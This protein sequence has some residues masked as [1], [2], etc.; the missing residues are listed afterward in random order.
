MEMP[1][2]SQRTISLL[3]LRWPASAIASWRDAFH[4]VAVG[5]EHIGVVV[6]EL[7]RIR[8]PA[9]ARRAPCRPRWRGPGRAGRWWSRCRG[10]AVFG[11]AGGLGA[12]LAEILELVEGHARAPVRDRA[13][14]RAASSRGRPTARSGRGRASADRRRRISGTVNSTVATSAAPIGRPGWPDLACST[15]SMA[16]ER[17]ALAIRSC[18]SREDI[19]P[20]ISRGNWG[21]WEPRKSARH[22]AGIGLESINRCVFAAA[23][24][25]QVTP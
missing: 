16:S 8:R 6:D 19:V 15:A 12:E 24:R 1:L 11:M 21:R 4:Q 7:R 20:P 23:L 2:S 18:F 10:E 9:C 5:G 14:H 17:I 3:S 13:A 25:R 22:I